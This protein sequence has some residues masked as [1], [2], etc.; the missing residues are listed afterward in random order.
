MTNVPPKN[1][2]LLSKSKMIKDLEQL[3][4]LPEGSQIM[5]MGTKVGKELKKAEGIEIE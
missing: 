5:V 1:L 3:K 2:K 4:A